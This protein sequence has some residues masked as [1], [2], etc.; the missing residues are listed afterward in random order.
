MRATIT[1]YKG[2]TILFSAGLFALSC[3]GAFAQQTTGVPGSPD[4]TTTIDGK[5]LPSPD[6]KFVGATMALRTVKTAR[7]TV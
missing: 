6:A 1:A 5:Q 4:A 7:R 2:T 3:V